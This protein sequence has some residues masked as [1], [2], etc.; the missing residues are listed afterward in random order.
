MKKTLTL[1]IILY[2]I[3][4]T[5]AMEHNQIITTFTPLEEDEIVETELINNRLELFRCTKETRK[6]YF[7]FKNFSKRGKWQVSGDKKNIIYYEWEKYGE[8]DN[9]VCFYLID[10]PKGEIRYL[11]NLPRFGV[12]SPD[13]NYYLYNNVDLDNMKIDII[14]YNL[15]DFSK[16]VITWKLK[17]TIWINDHPYAQ[18]FRQINEKNKFHIYLVGEGGGIIAESIFSIDDNIISSSYEIGRDDEIIHIYD[19]KFSDY[20]CGH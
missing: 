2:L 3:T 16:K 14:I 6:E 15:N 5:Y 1:L 19:L 11:T 18:I 10:G 13:F 17:S 7:S 9:T 20:E 8:I 4:K 12:T